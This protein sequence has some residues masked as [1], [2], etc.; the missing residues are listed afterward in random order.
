MTGGSARRARARGFTLLEVMVALA[1]LGLMLTSIL[2]AQA[3]LYGHSAQA[4]NLTL[5]TS[6]ARCKINEVDELLLKD[7]YPEIDRYDEGPCCNGESP[8]GLTCKWSI[9]RVTLPDPPAAD[10]GTGDAGSSGSSTSGGGG[11]GALGAL[12][13]AAASPSTLASG[14]ISGLSSALSQG[15]GPNGQTGVAGV[16]GM[17]MGIVYPQLKPLLE[18]S[19]RR[20]TVNVSWNEG[21]TERKVQLVLFATNPQKGLPPIT[22]L[23]PGA[24]GSAGVGLPAGLPPGGLPGGFPGAGGQTPP[25]MP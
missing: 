25:R 2:A 22:D 23:P 12:A 11:M 21:L 5:A 3:G 20:V 17:A 7:G 16:A 15:T 14:G 6:A 10:P 8:P 9:E 19:I 18:A 4:R 1:I 24:T 13:A